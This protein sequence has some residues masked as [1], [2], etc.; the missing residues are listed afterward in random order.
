MKILLGVPVLYN[1]HVVREC[2]NTIINRP[3]IDI[4]CLDNGA[5]QS[6]KDVIQEYGGLDQ[7]RIISLPN[8][9]YVNPAWNLFMDIFLKDESYTH[10]II[11]N[12]DL[13]MNGS[14]N[15]VLTKILSTFPDSI[16]LP[17][18]SLDKLSVHRHMTTDV[19]QHEA[20]FC[21]TPGVFICLNRGHVNIIYPIPEDIKI[22]HG[23]EWIYTI[24]REVG[25]TTSVYRNLESFHHGSTTLNDLENREG[26]L[27]ADKKVWAEKIEPMMQEKIKQ[28]KSQQ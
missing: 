16:P 3:N 15:N 28:L 14:W 26:L 22:W 18:I 7:L 2:L 20:V 21:C 12:S 11:L 5:E 4:I 25:Y 10:I 24:L 6:V 23:D 17:V 27:E 8:N 13:L 9:I 19:A 1:S